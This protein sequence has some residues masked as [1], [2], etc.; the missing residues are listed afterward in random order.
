MAEPDKTT[1]R[2]I[3]LALDLAVIV[4]PALIPTSARAIA[5]T[6]LAPSFWLR[7]LGK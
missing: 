4:S 6:K 5:D 1:I 2:A 3:L 7:N